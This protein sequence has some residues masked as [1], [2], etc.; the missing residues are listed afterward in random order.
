M[1]GMAG[2]RLVHALLTALEIG[3]VAIKHPI[4]LFTFCRQLFV[5]STRD[6]FRLVREHKMTQRLFQ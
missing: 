5:K 4:N 3:N 1:D 2:A 6:V